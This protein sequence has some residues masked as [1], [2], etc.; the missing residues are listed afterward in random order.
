MSFRLAARPEPELRQGRVEA[1]AGG[2]QPWRHYVNAYHEDRRL[3][4]TPLA[5]SRWYAANRAVL[6]P[7][8]PVATVGVVYSQRN[9][10]FFGRDDADLLVHQP[11]R[12]FLQALTRAGSR[13]VLVHADDLA[14][15]AGR[16]A[17]A[18]AAQP[19]GDGGTRR[20]PPC[21]R[22]SPAGAGWWPPAP[23]ASAMPLAIRAQTSRWRMSRRPPAAG[24]PH[25]G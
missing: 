1:F 15:S 5:L 17:L 14:N 19:G 3:Y 8:Q 18:C 11:Q 21:A 22:S 25:A 2:I 24:P 20:S 23:P 7:R 4:A 12:G 6:H 13:Y 9:L 16:A 10:D